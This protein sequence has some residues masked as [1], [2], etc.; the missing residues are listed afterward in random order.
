M[1]IDISI[2]DVTGKLEFDWLKKRTPICSDELQI[3]KISLISFVDLIKDNF[4]KNKDSYK[5][6]RDTAI[7][8]YNPALISSDGEHVFNDLGASFDLFNKEIEIPQ[9]QNGNWNR[10]LILNDADICITKPKAPSMLCLWIQFK[11]SLRSTNKS[12]P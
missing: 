5:E 4:Y 8:N 2:K 1:I 11:R 10:A 9:I 6:I 3:D 7:K 12:M